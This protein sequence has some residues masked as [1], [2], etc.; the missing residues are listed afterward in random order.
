M[1][2]V[3]PVEAS[4]DPVEAWRALDAAHAGVHAALEHELKKAHGLSAV[5][6]DVLDRLARCAE[7]KVR[8]TEL[9]EDVHVT[10]STCSRVVARLEDEGL[11]RRAMC[12]NDRR[13]IFASVTDVGR[14]RV[15]A[16]TPTYRDVIASRLGA[17]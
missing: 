2:A 5:E 1:R 8:M 12:D 9:A 6:F 3:S 17:R 10:Q 11:A 7:G 14:E 16:A 4:A 15:G 13:G